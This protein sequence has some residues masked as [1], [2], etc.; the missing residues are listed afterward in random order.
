MV[1]KPHFL[2]WV[3]TLIGVQE[4]HMMV[5]YTNRRKA[6][7]IIMEVCRNLMKPL[8]DLHVFRE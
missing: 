2:V 1:A 4:C 6:S 3:K 7:W 5:N 8:H